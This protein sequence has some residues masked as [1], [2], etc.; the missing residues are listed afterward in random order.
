MLKNII[1]LLFV[2]ISLSQAET[3]D[4]KIQKNILL[5]ENYLWL[6]TDEGPHTLVDRKTQY[7]IDLVQKILSD[8][9]LE[10][11]GSYVD[12]IESIQL[13]L[14]S[15]RNIND[16]NLYGFFPM[17]KYTTNDFFFFPQKP[18]VHTLVKNPKFLA[19]S[20]SI[21]SSSKILRQSHQRHVF[22]NSIPHD[23]EVENIAFD[24]FNQTDKLF[25]RF[26]KEV[27][28]ALE[29]QNEIKQYNENQITQPI[30]DKLMNYV[31]DDSI[32]L[33]TVTRNLTEDSDYY[34]TVSSKG[35]N[36]K[37]ID[38][39]MSTDAFGYT[40][41]ESH[42]WNNILIIHL[43]MLALVVLFLL[44]QEKRITL[45]N[46]S[47]VFILFIIG[48]AFPWFAITTLNTFKPDNLNHYLFSTWWVLAVGAGVFLLSIIGFKAAYTKISNYTSLPSIRG[49]GGIVGFSLT[50][51][52]IS[53]LSV[54]FFYL[55]PEFSLPTISFSFFSLVMLFSGY[56]MGKIIDVNYKIDEKYLLIYIFL[57]PL[58]FA[59]LMH[60]QFILIM[61][62][63]ALMA[64]V[65]YFILYKHG[66]IINSHI[67]NQQIESFDE[68][69]TESLP[70]NMN[71]LEFKTLL[72][73]PTYQKFTYFDEAYNKASNILNDQYTE[74]TL[75]G[76]GGAGK[77]RTAYVLVNRIVEELSDGKKK[78]LYFETM[79]DKNISPNAPF[80]IFHNLLDSIFDI[81]LFGQRVR[82][83][84]F[85]NVLNMA[86]TVLLGPVGAFFSSE[87]NESDQSF[88]KN[89]I[90]IFVKNKLIELS[91]HNTLIL[92]I[93]DIQW[94]D[95]SSLEL[96]QYLQ[97]HFSSENNNIMFIFTV[98]DDDQSNDVIS[99]LDLN[100]S[101]VSIGNID[102]NEQ[103]R[104][105]LQSLYLS[106]NAS[107]WLLEWFNSK[108]I[109]NILPSNIID[110]A[111]NLDKLKALQATE[112]HYEL[113]DEFDYD[114][115]PIPENNL[116]EIKSVFEENP[117]Y[118]Q[119][120]LI[121]AILGKE[122]NIVILSNI[123]KIEIGKLLEVLDEIS[124]NTN[125]LYDKLEK[126][127]YYNFRSQLI[128][129]SIKKNSNYKI[130]NVKSDQLS[131]IIMHT[132]ET[133]AIGLEK[134]YI[135]HQDHELVHQIAMHYFSAGKRLES[136]AYVYNLMA[137]EKT[138]KLFDYDGA[139]LY[140]HKLR[141]LAQT[142]GID[143]QS[144]VNELELIIMCEKS[145]VTGKGAI[146]VAQQGINYLE[147]NKN[148]SQKLKVLIVRSSYEAALSNYDQMW[149]KKTVDL[150]K[151][152]L[153]TSSDILSQV[154]GNHFIGLSLK[155]RD[156]EEKP[157]IKQYLERALE[158][159]KSC[160]QFVFARIANSVAGNLSYG[161]DQDKQRAVA[162]FEESLAIKENAE[163]KDLPG[164]ARSCGGLGRYYFFNEPDK[165]EMARKYLERDLE[166]SIEIE[167]SRGISQMNSLLGQC[168]I[169]EEKY[170]DAI[171]HFRD[172]IMQRNN[173][174]D[175][176]KSYSCLFEV[177]D[178]IKSHDEL[179][180][181]FANF[182][183]MVEEFGL[184]NEED[185]KN[186]IKNTLSKHADLYKKLDKIFLNNSK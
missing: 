132:H 153:I 44:Y 50:A 179:F 144:E 116:E 128:V 155:P 181:E 57:V 106:P 185:I 164:I 84:G 11:H 114:N 115:T 117:D 40:I 61:I 134:A 138:Q 82:D 68:V 161:D 87:N 184:L 154:E 127:D 66:K 86:S 80:S 25:P 34:Y 96:L 163:I 140:V 53:F 65:N 39:L 56:V 74:I 149:F 52:S 158:L 170:E 58:L 133:V 103:K 70:A 118:K 139:M 46:L 141:E 130:K 186:N 51:G 77:T 173:I 159:S 3:V 143:K 105:L 7:Y 63:S 126:D 79:C 9:N 4:E 99:K 100:K 167:D 177:L 107:K 94:A 42:N 121:A 24:I 101:I 166:V 172:S 36:K 71:E 150:A 122:F 95:D 75:K 129:D 6:T 55:F 32:Y 148:V 145:H 178:K 151:Q 67:H 111:V 78:I 23:P 26:Y 47:L 8:T 109:E 35:Y 72:E 152:Y 60:L 176:Y 174:Y 2:L 48:R 12:K 112:H 5:A 93:D 31:G 14:N 171:V 169:K 43:S 110:V 120:L 131:Q 64:F 1:V 54:S 89:D 88:S 62:L 119:L 146:D 41:D 13:Q 104:M 135:T 147:S 182:T 183:K 137:C 85:D 168:D 165:L 98:R 90:F 162:L 69:S 16:E 136:K 83:K 160:D 38:K 17:L 108:Q 37:G 29:D 30:V 15:I 124:E 73:K 21:K 59:V 27:V 33:V 18:K 20:N 28:T 81:D 76:E 45:Q 125:L 19:V 91:K 180:E 10:S 157:L 22:I 92:F 175:M 49:K 142:M 102:I 123:L 113:S 156:E 97:K